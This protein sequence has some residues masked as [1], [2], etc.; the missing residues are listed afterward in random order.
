MIVGIKQNTPQIEDQDIGVMVL[1][2]EKATKK[3]S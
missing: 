2:L 1:K 3:Y